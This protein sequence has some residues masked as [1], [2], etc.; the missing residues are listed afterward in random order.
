M[1][2]LG[3]LGSLSVSDCC[4]ILELT[5][6]GGREKEKEVC[7]REGGREG[8]PTG[9]VRSRK[10]RLTS[11]NAGSKAAHIGY[12]RDTIYILVPECD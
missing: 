6:E 2:Q 4:R 1:W 7:A 3:N 12:R 8:G 11:D 9:A 5:G 10:R